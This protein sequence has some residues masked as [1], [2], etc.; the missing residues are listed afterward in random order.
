MPTIFDII[1]RLTIFSI[2]DV[3]SNSILLLEGKD[4]EDCQVDLKN[5]ILCYLLIDNFIYPKSKVVTNDLIY[6]LCG[7]KLLPCYS[8]IN[9][10]MNY[11]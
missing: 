4:G 5:Y 1:K 9:V 7:K 8:I 6:F 2:K 3:F 11:I 10:K